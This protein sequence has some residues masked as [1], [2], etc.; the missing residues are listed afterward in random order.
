MDHPHYSPDLMHSDSY[1]F[2][3]LAGKQ[4]A[5]DADVT[6]ALTP[7]SYRHLTLISSVLGYKP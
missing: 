2:R 4:F 1:L 5:I 3:P 7:T 6:Q